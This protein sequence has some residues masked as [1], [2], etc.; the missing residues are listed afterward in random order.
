MLAM[1]ACLR[2]E[3]AIPL[4]A[5]RTA[6]SSLVYL[7]LVLAITTMCFACLVIYGLTHLS[8]AVSHVIP[9]PFLTTLCAFLLAAS[10]ILI[11]WSTGRKQI[12]VIAISR[13]VS[14]ISD[15]LFKVAIAFV[16]ITSAAILAGYSIGLVFGIISYIWLL[17]YFGA[18]PVV[19]KANAR[20]RILG[21]LVTHRRYFQTGL[22]EALCTSVAMQAPLLLIAGLFGAKQA[23]LLFV[24]QQ[25]MRSPITL[26]SNAIGKVF[27]S[28]LAR[29]QRELSVG[30]LI[31]NHISI[32]SKV[33]VPLVI[34]LGIA[35]S[36]F[37]EFVFGDE[38]SELGTFLIWM[39]PWM[40]MVMVVSPFTT[41]L[42]SSG[43]FQS[44]LLLAV[45][46]LV[47]RVGSVY[48]S[49]TF[50][51]EPIIALSISSILTYLIYGLNISRHAN[52]MIGEWLQSI[53]CG[54]P[55]IGM[56]LGASGII[57]V[58]KGVWF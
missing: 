32:Q 6:S 48:A 28:D 25:V 19:R 50:S 56:A 8:A 39:V 31:Q 23:A 33:G 14:S 42:Y 27:L 54:A 3:Q 7:A 2:Y 18:F 17:K 24:A 34:V 40:I 51:V 10:N 4:A 37:A 47:L 41:V 49:Y 11:M 12:K 1:I 53:C 44:A 57:L 36:A 22:V 30:E 21:A 5:S 9:H 52:L 58:A 15:A 13:V 20:K 43:A 45:L 35:G 46:G 55:F 38:Y 26:I 16:A 29:A